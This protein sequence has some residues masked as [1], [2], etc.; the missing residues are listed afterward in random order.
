MGSKTV[1]QGTRATIALMNLL[2]MKDTTKI[3]FN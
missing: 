2:V 1:E 3:D